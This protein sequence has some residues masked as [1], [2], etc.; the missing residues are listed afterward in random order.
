MR[1]LLPGWSNPPAEC[2]GNWTPDG[3]YFVFE[4]DR[5]FN[6]TLWA[7]REKSGFL[8]QA[9]PRTN[10]VD[11]GPKQH[12]QPGAEPGR[13]EALCDSRS[14]RGQL[15]RYDAK[16]QQFVPYL[17]GISAIQL[18]IFERW[19]MGRLYVVFRT[20]LCGAAKWT[21][22]SGFSFLLPPWSCRAPQWSPDG[23]QIAFAAITRAKRMHIYIVSADGGTPKE[24]TKGE[25]DRILSQLVAGW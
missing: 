20:E 13:E 8:T 3:N 22:R 9:Q 21:E 5:G 24:V 14:Y 1:P 16:S 10:T 6:S 4:S 7:I 18:G 17:S 11:H 15:V 19:A 23:K 2:C 12:V 25:R